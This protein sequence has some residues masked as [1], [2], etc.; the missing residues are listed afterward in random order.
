MHTWP[1]NIQGVQANF[2]RFFEAFTEFGIDT[3]PEAHTNAPVMKCFCT[4]RCH[5]PSNN[6]SNTLSEEAGDWAACAEAFR[7]H[8]LVTHYFVYGTSLQGEKQSSWNV[9]QLYFWPWLSFFLS[10]NLERA[11]W[12][13]KVEAFWVTKAEGQLVN[14]ENGEGLCIPFPFLLSRT[15]L[16]WAD[17]GRRVADP[18]FPPDSARFLTACHV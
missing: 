11:I 4:N 16:E 10:E 15:R 17:K 12:K 13:R 5:K 8:T 9:W 2:I 3:H 7:E 6:P 14:K 18:Y 1:S